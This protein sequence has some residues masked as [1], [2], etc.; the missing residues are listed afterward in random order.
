MPR[1]NG[2]KKR[3]DRGARDA[4]PAQ[5]VRGGRLVAAAAEQA[6]HGRAVPHADDPAGERPQAADRRVAGIG[7]PPEATL[8]ADDRAALEQPELEPVEVERRLRLGV[9]E[10]EN[11][12]AVVEQEAVDGVGPHAAADRV[13]A[14][15]HERRPPGG[16][17]RAGAGEAGHPRPDDDDVVLGH[18]R[19]RI[20]GR[21]QR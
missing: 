12:E 21:A 20:V 2:A 8:R 1:R 19:E 14:L 4:G 17:Q 13:G 18:A 16:G 11:L 7:E 3:L 15:E 6:E 10:G 5:R 9:G